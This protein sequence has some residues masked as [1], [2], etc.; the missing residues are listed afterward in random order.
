MTTATLQRETFT[1]SREMEFFQERELTAQ[2][3]IDRR[4]W[5]FVILKELMDN[6]L[7][8]CETAGVAPELE[9]TVGENT[10]TVSD[11]GPGL[12]A[13]VITRI[14]DFNTRTSDKE[15][16]RSPTRGQQG[17]ALKTI[18]GMS[19]C[20]GGG[21]VIIEARGIR[22]DVR[23]TL[24]AI[25]QKPDISHAQEEIVKNGGTLITVYT[26]INL[27]EH[28]PSLLQILHFYTLFSPHLTIR[29][30]VVGSD[31]EW[32]NE[33]SAEAW[34]KWVPSDPTSP[35]WY[36]QEELSRLIGAH[37][38]KA[39]DDGGR[40]Y[41]LGEF[42]RQ[43]KGLSGSPTRKRITDALP[44]ARRLSDLVNGNGLDAAKV[45][46]LLRTMKVESKPVPPEALGIIGEAHFKAVLHTETMQYHCHKH[47]GNIPFV[48]EAAFC[49]DK[50][51]E[52]PDVVLGLNFAPALGD[53]FAYVDL[54]AT[55][56]KK[57]R[58]GY[59][60]KGLAQAFGL[61]DY[62]YIGCHLVLHIVHPALS[63]RDRGK[64][65][66]V[67]DDELR[68]AVGEAVGHVLK[69]H[70]ALQEKS[71]REEEAEERARR[72]REKI[73]RSYIPSIKEAVFLVL[74]EAADKAS[75]GG[76]YL[77]SVRQLYYAVRPLIQQYTEAKLNYAYFTPQ[78]VTEYE[79]AHGPLEK[80]VY[81]ARGHLIT[82]HSRASIPLGTK[83]VENYQIPE[84]EYDKI[85][86]I[87]KEGFNEI[88]NEAE[89]G[90]RYDMAIMTAKGYAPRAAKQLLSRARGREISILV[91]H[92][93]DL[94]GY[95]IRRTIADATRTSKLSIK[96]IDIGLTKDEALGMGLPQERVEN[97]KKREAPRALRV[98]VT[99]EELAW[100]KQYRIELN[101]MT[102][103]QLIPWIERKL[104]EHGLARKVVP[105][106]DM[107]SQAIKTGVDLNLTEWTQAAIRRAFES[108]IG[109]S[110]SV[111]ASE[112]I[113]KFEKP[114]TTGH[115][116]ELTSYMTSLPVDNWQTWAESK[117]LRL[118][119]DVTKELSQMAEDK[120]RGLIEAKR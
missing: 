92:D 25:A 41:P 61:N 62:S 101:A 7:D 49:Y 37:V 100:L 2:V 76:K 115:R 73:A 119:L 79:D 40:D 85:L 102:S 95:E 55:Y 120:I 15:A 28:T 29:T 99:P 13:D 45:G 38:A 96:I 106:D 71:N 10:I 57:D 54:P 14:L 80:L 30:H 74:R 113:D 20:M 9:V 42:L 17:N 94:Y 78:L 6:A 26:A 48:V 24:D 117:A 87:E 109:T 93:A 59:G 16:Y 4:R 47:K 82:P 75:G 36:T 70:C 107:L 103:D 51:I 31:T 56:R 32:V 86:Y 83:D 22:H 52:S 44:G 98:Q 58:S 53:P 67:A 65:Q 114:T 39:R 8:A 91:A 77:C 34:R 46:E 23:I 60:V 43:F 110:L 116:E 68:K 90:R 64:S 18:V 81:D 105:P 21:R 104:Q 69:E 35:H 1:V 11:N 50:E 89:L 112:L 12:P 84:W 3:G 63:F 66:I 33:R 108:V 97:K 88:F 19:F 111:L 118:G 27:W 5:P 72:Q